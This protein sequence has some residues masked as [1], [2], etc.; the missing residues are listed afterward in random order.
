MKHLVMDHVLMISLFLIFAHGI[1]DDLD[2]VRQCHE[3]G[4]HTA[5]LPQMDGGHDISP[6]GVGLDGATSQDCLA[7]CEGDSVTREEVVA[8][9]K[10]LIQEERVL[11]RVHPLAPI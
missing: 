1:N 4:F 7:P 10:G 2:V 9:L 11:A 3:R 6:N 5:V 8:G